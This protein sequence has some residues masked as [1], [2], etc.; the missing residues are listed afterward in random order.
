M[1]TLIL[2]TYNEIENLK[3]LLPILESL[4]N[5][6]N[7]IYEIIVVDDDSPDRTWH[8]VQTYSSKNSNIRVIRRITEKGLSSAVVTGMASSNG[9]IIGVM[10]ADMQHDESIIPKMIESLKVYDIVIGSRISKDGSYGDMNFYRKILSLGAIFLAKILLPIK[11][12]DPM[13][14]FFILKKDI[15]ERSKDRINPRGYK[16]LLEFLAKNPNIKI[17][18]IGYSF[19]K[20]VHGKTKLSGT[21]IQQYLIALIDL[22]FGPYFSWIFIKYAITGFLGIFINL[23]GQ[24]TFNE[25][26][27]F[28]KI[29]NN[30]DNLLFP[31]TAVAFGFELSVFFNFLLNNYWTFQDRSRIGIKNQISAFIKFN[32]VS[33]IGFTIQYSCWIFILQIFNNFEPSIFTGYTTYISNLIG[34]LIATSTNYKLNSSFTW[35]KK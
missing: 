19:R 12:N 15:F 17:S 16:I 24:Y 14:G 6:N 3:V 8:W 29:E 10:D 30:N 25:I 21:I 22:R 1:F 2:P 5:D 33:L 18:E 34:I 31:S 28:L 13:S 4:F 35:S 23:L 11:S 20:R 7:I 26:S 9:E 32:S 27:I